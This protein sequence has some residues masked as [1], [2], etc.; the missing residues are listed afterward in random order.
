MQDLVSIAAKLDRSNEK[1]SLAKEKVDARVWKQLEA[2]SLNC[3]SALK[4]AEASR[5]PEDVSLFAWIV[6]EFSDEV[7]MVYELND[8]HELRQHESTP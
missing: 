3:R 7:D 1:L 5:N 6:H 4:M 2:D 8:L